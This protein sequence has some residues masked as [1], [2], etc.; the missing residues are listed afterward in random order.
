VTTTVHICTYTLKLQNNQRGQNYK[1]NFFVEF[2]RSFLDGPQP[3]FSISS[4]SC[5][6]KKSLFQ[7]FVNNNNCATPLAFTTT[8]SAVAVVAVALVACVTTHTT[9]HLPHTNK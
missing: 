9:E 8:A 4:I 6:R 3:I 2:T 7:L 5:Q 1:F